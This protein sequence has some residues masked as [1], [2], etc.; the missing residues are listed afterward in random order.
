MGWSSYVLIDAERV[1]R[2]ADATNDWQWIHLDSDRATKESTFGGPVAHGFLSLSL[3]VPFLQDVVGDV[4]G[5]MTRINVGV[6]EVRFKQPVMVG[7][8]L[9]ARFVLKSLED[10]RG[11]AQATYGI[12][13]WTLRQSKKPHVTVESV[14]RYL[15]DAPS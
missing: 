1:K 14:I 5:A 13:C 12:E 3:V 4:G 15:R 7:D 11:G 10:C 2:F 6:N 9:R 8:S